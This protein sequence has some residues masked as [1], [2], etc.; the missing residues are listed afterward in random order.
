[1]IRP[2]QPACIALT[3]IVRLF[4]ALPLAL[5]FAS[6]GAASIAPAAES[7]LKVGGTGTAI[8]TMKI[9]ADAFQKANPGLNVN[10]LPSVG[11]TGGVKA[12]NAGAIDLGVSGR[13]LTDAERASGAVA[14]EY[15]RSPVVLAVSP[16]TGVSGITRRELIDIYAAKMTHWSNGTPVRLVLRPQAD[17]NTITLKTLA[18][19]VRDAVTAAEKR[20]GMLI[21]L[22]DQDAIEH[23]EKTPGAL[24]PTALN[25]IIASRLR[26]IALSLDGVVPSP[27]ALGDGS[28]P[29]F[30]RYFL[31]TGKRMDAFAEKFIAFVRSE[32]GQSILIE[33][34]HAPPERAGAR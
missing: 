31:V 19:E 4:R 29:L 21:A 5:A 8:G 7:V 9:L 27:A 2:D 34:G 28:Y 24:G 20:R 22:T 11:S 17:T 12:V 26:L 16:A 23:L 15:G 18:P 3:R 10:V 6:L 13:P 1:M 25:E 32:A 30:L 33:T 14:I